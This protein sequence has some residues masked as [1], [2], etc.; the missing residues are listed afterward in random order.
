M[1]GTEQP[2]PAWQQL[3]QDPYRVWQWLQLPLWLLLIGWLVVQLQAWLNRPLVEI[4]LQGE[5]QQLDAR[6]LEQSLWRQAD[7]GFA[8]TELERFKQQL[9]LLPWVERVQLRRR[10]PEGVEIAVYE[11]QPVARWGLEG[12]VNERGK[13]FRPADIAE[14]ERQQEFKGLPLLQGPEQHSL[15]LMAQYRDINQLLRPLGVSLSG[16]EME[17]RGAWTLQLNN[18]IQLVVGR[19]QV[20]ER[21]R[22]FSKV[23]GE[24]LSRYADRIVQIDVRYTNGLAVTWTQPPEPKQ[25]K[26]KDA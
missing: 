14:V 26:K 11:Q 20:V 21:L 13:V 25:N 15:N 3:L 8:L 18:G 4:E 16:L 5:F 6:L 23:Y 22:R 24:L 2:L 10:W 17:A 1:T 9:E 19:G 12:L 7:Q